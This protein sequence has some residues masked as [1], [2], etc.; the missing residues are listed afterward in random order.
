MTDKKISDL[1]QSKIRSYL[2]YIYHEEI[3]GTSQRESSAVEYLSKGLQ[4]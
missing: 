4:N 2:D 1:L 3:S